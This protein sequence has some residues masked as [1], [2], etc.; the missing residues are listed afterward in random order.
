MQACP[1]CRRDNDDAA[2]RCGGCGTALILG[3]LR[4]VRGAYTS[5]HPLRGNVFSIGRALE[6]D[7]CLEDRAVS[8]FHARLIADE[9][10]FFVEDLGSRFG[11]YVDDA[12]VKRAGLAPGSRIRIGDTVLVFELP[13]ASAAAPP[14]EHVTTGSIPV[15]A[16]QDLLLSVLEA[17]NSTLVLDAVLE[18][19]LDAVMRITRAERGFLLLA[20]EGPEEAGR[21]ESVA[22]FRL[23]VGRGATG[24]SGIST[25]ILRNVQSTGVTVATGNAVED[26]SIGH[27]QSVM[28]LSLR[29]V[30]CIPL[31][32]PDTGP[33]G[34]PRVLG[35]IY[36]DNQALSTAFSDES[37]KAAEALSRHAALAIHNAQLFEREQRTIEELR[38]ARDQALEASRAKTAFLATM[39]HELHTP[40]NAIIGYGEIIGERAEELGEAEMLG[41]LAKLLEAARS[42]LRLVDGVLD[43]SNL[44]GGRMVLKP[45]RFELLPLL[46]E[47]CATAFAEAEKNRNAFEARIAPGLGAILADP[48]RLKQVLGNLLANATKFTQAGKV[49]LDVRRDAGALVFEVSDTGIGMTPEQCTRVFELFSQADSSYTRRHGGTGLGLPL[50]RRLCEAMGGSLTVESRLG[51]GSKFV[52]RVPAPEA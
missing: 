49:Q 4:V 32:S 43:V 24:V 39:S 41:D 8:R 30:V 11:V 9:G 45:R 35:A 14:P 22:G 31:R 18:K 10:R 23:R 28:G 50:S 6:N 52:A 16:R 33:G 13:G 12:K 48:D 17:I 2:E 46:R 44:E 26:P 51:A 15:V 20:E 7:L 42:L 47:L 40:L 37:L 21:F 34:A 25:S 5:F 36:V 27:S 29:T 3:G 1:E 38:V 19:I